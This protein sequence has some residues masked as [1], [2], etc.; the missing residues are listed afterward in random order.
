MVIVLAI[1][2][3]QIE[4]TKLQKVWKLEGKK[5]SKQATKQTARVT[6]CKDGSEMIAY[7]EN[8]FKQVREQESGQANCKYARSQESN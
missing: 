1:K 8:E 2:G 6:E 3:D 5:E 4:Q 7:N